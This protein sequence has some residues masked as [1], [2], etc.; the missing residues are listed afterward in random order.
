MTSDTDYN[1]WTNKPTWLV[2]LWID[3]DQGSQEHWL[4]L[5]REA[6]LKTRGYG[7]NAAQQAQYG[8]ARVL[9]EAFE[10]EAADLNGVAGFFSDLMSWALAMVNWDEVANSLIED[11]AEIKR[12][13]T[14]D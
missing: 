8:L 2:K 9:R 10:D 11:A 13:A 6:V 14:L 4:F 1:G 7:K 5:A 12:L 3:N